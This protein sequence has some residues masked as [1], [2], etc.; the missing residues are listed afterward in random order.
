MVETAVFTYGLLA[1]FILSAASRN[2]R[3]QRPNPPMMTYLGYVLLGM[4]AAAAVL[5]GGYAA[6]QLL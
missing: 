5:L 2:Q 1:S 6:W 4:S 3:M